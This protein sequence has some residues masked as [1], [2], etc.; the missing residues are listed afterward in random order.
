MANEMFRTLFF[1]ALCNTVVDMSTII[2]PDSIKNSYV[3][4]NKLL[5]AKYKNRVG[6]M[7]KN[8]LNRDL[9]R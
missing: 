8:D 5:V 1:K 9:M 4:R 6:E 7:K 3:D 2:N